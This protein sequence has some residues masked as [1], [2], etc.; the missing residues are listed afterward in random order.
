MRDWNWL[1]CGVSLEREWRTLV[2]YWEE[3]YRAATQSLLHNE[4]KINEENGT[5]LV[6]RDCVC[7]CLLMQS[8]HDASTSARFLLSV[9]N[10]LNTHYKPF[11]FSD[12][13]L[14]AEHQPLENMT[15]TGLPHMCLW[16][17]NGVRRRYAE[18]VMFA[19]LWAEYDQNHVEISYFIV[20]LK[21]QSLDVLLC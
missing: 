1:W 14:Y 11:I 2:N 8:G 21:R 3:K 10:S 16:I 5:G 19:H 12:C 7:V 6:T 4:T 15:F 17:L 9:Y 20:I 18:P 13:R